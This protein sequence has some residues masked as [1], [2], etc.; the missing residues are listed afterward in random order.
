MIILAFILLGLIAGG[1]AG[2]IGVGGGIIIVPALVYLFHFQQKTAQGTTL[3]LLIPPIGIAAA[4]VY[5]KAGNVDFKAAGII[6]VGFLIGSYISSRFVAGM[7]SVM[8]ARIF[9][10]FL[11][12]IGGKML[13]SG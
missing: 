1:L 12:M 10:L 6:I 8:L 4:Y 5:W 3:A 11:L 13:I 2:M 9:G 7:N